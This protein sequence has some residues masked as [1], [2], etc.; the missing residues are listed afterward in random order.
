[1]QIEG[2]FGEYSSKGERTNLKRTINCTKETLANRQS[3][4]RSRN[5]K[6]IKLKASVADPS[7]DQEGIEPRAEGNRAETVWKDRIAE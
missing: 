6:K 3:Q 7:F 2:N 5:A 4:R 1:M